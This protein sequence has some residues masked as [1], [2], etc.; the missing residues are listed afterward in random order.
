MELLPLVCLCLLSCSGAG[1]LSK[2]SVK[3]L[4]E[5]GDKVLLQCEVQGTFP[6]PTVV[7]QTLTGE[8]FPSMKTEVTKEDGSYSIILETTVT[9][10]SFCYCFAKLEGTREMSVSGIFAFSNFDIVA[11][12]NYLGGSQIALIVVGVT[13]PVAVVLIL[14]IYIYIKRRNGGSTPVSTVAL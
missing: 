1:A 8:I 14:L 2:P 6:K 12:R 4:D 13:F 9:R 3:I 10:G 5:K 11:K 7:W